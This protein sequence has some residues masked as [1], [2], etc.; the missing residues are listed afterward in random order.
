VTLFIFRIIKSYAFSKYCRGVRFLLHVYVEISKNHMRESPPLIN[1]TTIIHKVI[2]T[3]FRKYINGLGLFSTL[4]R[5]AVLVG[6]ERTRSSVSVRMA[7]YDGE[8]RGRTPASL[9][10]WRAIDKWRC[11]GHGVLRGWR[12]S[13]RE[14]G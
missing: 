6:K 10:G 13:G 3:R 5:T 9:H 1:I 2:Q 4:G 11:H 7:R 14:R 12:S 8:R